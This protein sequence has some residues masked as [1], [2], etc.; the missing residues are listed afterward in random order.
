V[1]TPLSAPKRFS[2]PDGR[3]LA[4]C[5]GCGC[6]EEA[7]ALAPDFLIDFGCCILAMRERDAQTAPFPDTFAFGECGIVVRYELEYSHHRGREGGE[8]GLITSNL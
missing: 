8:Q 2:W 1:P 5:E 6:P 7:P 4:K 3:I